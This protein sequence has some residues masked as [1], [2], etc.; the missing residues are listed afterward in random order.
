[1]SRSVL[2]ALALVVAAPQVVRAQEGGENVAEA[3]EAKKVAK[4]Y[5]D[6]VVKAAEGK[7]PKPADVSKKLTAVRKLIHP[8]TL[9][10]IAEQE[11]RKTVTVGVA[12][13]HWAKNDYWLKEYELKDV[14]PGVNGTYIVETAEKNWRVEEGGEDSEPEQSSYLIGKHK[15]KWYVVDKRR[16]GTFDK[17]AIKRGYKGYFD[18]EE[19]DEAAAPAPAE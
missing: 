13:W 5:L 18:A 8:K 3:E 11:K 16:N 7:K 9:E 14:K 6:Q 19:K 2:L 17:G 15:G 4:Q 10:L 12:V 1:M